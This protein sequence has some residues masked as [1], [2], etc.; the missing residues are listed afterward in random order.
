MSLKAFY[1]LTKPGIIYGN[2]FS[3]TSG[4]MLACKFHIDYALLFATLLGIALVIA[5]ACVFNNLIDR[6]ID[7]VMERTKKR[8]LVVGTINEHVASFYGIVLGAIGFSILALHT[9]MLTVSLG[10]VAFLDYVVLY[11]IAKRRWVAGTIVGSVAGALPP[12][13]GYTAVT[14]QLD[15]AA[16]LLFF[17]MV[18][19]Q[20]PHFYAIAMYR[21][22]DYKAANLPVLP[23]KKGMDRAKKSIMA[24]IVVFTFAA[25]GLTVFGHTGYIYAVVVAGLGMAW[26]WKGWSGYNK[27]KPAVWGRKMFL[28]SL[29]VMVSISIIIPLGAV[30]P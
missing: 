13:A 9:N 6:D 12:V 17:I 21:F 30:L 20:M 24:Y 22:K 23:V 18:F 29:I 3:T 14:G 2:L 28:F 25:L 1:R 11:G 26:L 16:I 4:F 5:S 19:W 15:S 27:L 10:V 7:A 8:A